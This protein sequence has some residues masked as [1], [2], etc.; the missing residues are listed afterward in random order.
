MDR[1]AAWRETDALTR[2]A[3]KASVPCSP[4]PTNKH[5]DARTHA[6][7]YIFSQMNQEQTIMA[8]W[9][10]NYS[11][12]GI[13]HKLFKSDSV[14]SQLQQ[15]RKRAGGR[16]C[17]PTPACAYPFWKTPSFKTKDVQAQHSQNVYWLCRQVTLEVHKEEKKKIMFNFQCLYDLFNA[18]WVNSVNID[19]LMMRYE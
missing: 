18:G 7:E 5:P 9:P 13:I 6:H 4:S 10:T 17:T 8:Q 16:A 11:P 2:H 3:G 12:T 1:E 14:K 15:Q 19:L